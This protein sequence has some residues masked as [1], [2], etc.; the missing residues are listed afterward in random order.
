[1]PKAKFEAA[2]KKN[3]KQTYSQH[4]K[5][6]MNAYSILA[7]KGKKERNESDNR[8]SFREDVEFTDTARSK[9]SAASGYSSGKETVGSQ[10][11]DNPRYT[12]LR[13]GLTREQTNR[14]PF[15]FYEVTKMLGSGSMGDVILVRKKADR[16]G[17]SARKDI[18][19]AVRRQQRAKE[20]LELPLV[21]NMFQ[22]CI[23]GD[24]KVNK[25]GFDAA[26][27]SHH[28][29]STESTAKSSGDASSFNGSLISSAASSDSDI[30]Y[31]LKSIHLDQ[32]TNQ[33]FID[34]LRNEIA[35]LKDLDHPNIVRAIETFEFKGKISTVMELCSGGDLYS[36]EPYTE[37]EAARILSSILSAITYMHS[38]NISHRDLKF[39]NVLFANGSPMS[40]IKLIDF[41]LSHVYIDKKLTD[42]V[43]TI[44]T[45]APEVILGNHTDKAD[46]WSIGVIA[47]ML[48]S[49]AFPFWGRER[50]EVARRIINCEY[51]FKG[52]RWKKPSTQA[53][54][55]IKQLLVT[56][57]DERLDA[58]SALGS[59]WLNR[60]YDSKVRVPSEEEENMARASI[61]RY[62]GYTKLKKLALMVVAHKSSSEEI[63]I[64][65]KV[66]KKYD[67]R[68]DGSIWF[69][70]FCKA[71]GGLGH[72]DEELRS[73]F[74]AVDLDGSNRI[75]YTEFIAATIE[76][77]G[78]ISEARLAEAFD[79]LDS[80]DSGYITAEDLIG[81]LG[82]NF[83]RDEI[84]AI[85]A[86][87]DL[88]EDRS[89]SYSEFL[90]LWGN[91]Q[92]L[93][94]P[95]DHSM[96][97]VSNISMESDDAKTEE[98]AAH[99]EFLMEK[100][101][102]NTLHTWSQEMLLP[103]KEFALGCSFLHQV[104]LGNQAEL[105]NI[106]NEQ[107]TFV[108]FRDYDRRTALH[109]AAS[110]GHVGI[111]QYLVKNGA[112]VN[113]SDRWG[114]FPLDD[115]HRHRHADVV[116]VLREHGAKFGSTSQTVNLITAASQGNAEE[117]RTLL[118][119]GSI[120]LNQGDYDR[121]TALHL[122][123]NEGHLEA[124][125]LLCD[126]GADV[127]VKDRWGDRPLDDA[128]NAKKNSTEIVKIL[129]GAG[130]V[131]SL[132]MTESSSL[133]NST[134]QQVA[135][136]HD[137][138]D[139]STQQTVDS[140][141]NQHQDAGMTQLPVQEFAMGCSLLH[142]AALGNQLVLE[143]I[144]QGQPE[145]VNFR[146]YDRR[147]SLH[148][149][150]SEGQL[151]ICRYLV[152]KGA[153]INRCDR[154]GGSPLDDAHRHRHGEVVKY[155]RKNG[156]KFGSTSQVTNFI[157]A[158]SEGDVEEVEAFLDFGSVD[159]NQGDYDRRTA[160][161]LA[162]SEG[163]LKIVFLLCNAEAD[164]NVKDRWGHR[165]LDD[166]RNAKKNSSDIMKLL[167]KHGAKS[168][169]VSTLIRTA[170]LKYGSG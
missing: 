5:K 115:A 9:V 134:S 72:S 63:G 166:A 14:N 2:S 82:Q 111:C 141:P 68:S 130:A 163:H 31:A 17:G 157:T 155:L 71:M 23:D 123:A 22:Y 12:K 61:V 128:K 113:R 42:V 83:P 133:T 107:P 85:I 79:C 60:R 101:L 69:E 118:E 119:F 54:E 151:G 52:K 25:R 143:K 160:L 121:R 154:W 93:S 62:A 89:V 140:T 139:Q 38:R 64:L 18:Q 32:F 116:N 41:G 81:I 4:P 37:A 142:Q 43:G 98:S 165:P 168:T 34:E 110:E 91:Q 152:E 108:N 131:S 10:A 106:L 27:S 8:V 146:D 138:K 149:A 48:L 50:M 153:R 19:E 156:A 132:N 53:K 95:F 15:F 1:M 84:N 170:F 167:L 76:A 126:A 57:P 161:H 97:Q 135:I 137:L 24:L 13:S 92:E 80:D 30:I 29:Y 74:D 70:D 45:M 124:V 36:R 78:A 164:V 46:M 28:T 56:D 35:I 122:A 51:K 47:F 16:V 99:T 87:A 109:I 145:L 148:I 169:K 33:E 77:H 21:G 112:R 39:E 65:R 90:A 59:A 3:S 6:N 7:E 162:A 114:G 144:L 147:T 88:T 94:K 120:D 96:R 158:A 105:E 58:E 86:E 127:K 44:Y 100:H 150:A 11:S 102:Q 125:K 129:N 103:A 66:F 75:R 20:C 55:F 136:M 159:L 73:L 40:D 104:A 67:L 49:S 26:N 117:V